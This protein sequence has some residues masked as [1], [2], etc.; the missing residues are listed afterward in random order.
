MT[1][2]EHLYELRRRLA[3]AVAA[4]AVGSVLGFIWYNAQPFGLPSL[5]SILIGPYCDLP[6]SSRATFDPSG[7]CRLLATA[8]FE[9]F[10]L[11]LKVGAA[12]GALLSSPVWFG[13]IWGFITPGLY[14]KEKR[15]AYV[16]VTIAVTLFVAGAVLAYFV[17]A[18]AMTFLLGI[19]DSTQFT[20]LRGSD[21][22]SFL[23]TLLVI[24]GV[25]FELPLVTV[26][27]NRVGVLPY[28]KLRA[29]RRGLIFGLFV[30]AAVATPGSDPI[31]MLALGLSL[32]LLLELAI[33]ISRVHDKRAA[34]RRAAEGFPDVDWSDLD[35]DEPSSLGVRT[36]SDAVRTS[37]TADPTPR[38]TPVH[39]SDVSSPRWPDDST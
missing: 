30:F 18:Q 24:F 1:L 39:Q 5:G 13:Q 16:F 35:P 27:L 28:A 19:G 33:Q 17:V 14:A 26:M 2:V 37:P 21:Y 34:R 36:T 23:I 25:S 12:A 4:L 22:F 6:A 10:M 29:W 32:T 7:Q 8:L 31:S 11:R 20:A 3:V 15:F 38:I 9:E